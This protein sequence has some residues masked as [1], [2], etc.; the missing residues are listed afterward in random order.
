MDKL[1][2]TRVAFVMHSGWHF[3]FQ[4]AHHFAERF[5]RAGLEVSVF[6]VSGIRSLVENALTRGVSREQR[7][8]VDRLHTAC[9]PYRLA[10]RSALV[11]R[12]L[13]PV[14]ARSF[15]RFA[16]REIGPETLVWLHGVNYVLPPE[17]LL[18][19]EHGFSLVDIC[20][21]F[22]AFFPDDPRT[23]ARLLDRERRTAAGNDL[24]LASAGRL[25][26]RL[27]PMSRR[28]ALV[29]NGVSAAFLAAGALPPPPGRRK[30]VAAYQGAFASWF[31]WE[32]FEEVVDLLPDVEFRLIGRVYADVRDRMAR[33]EARP[34]VKAVGLLPHEKL[35]AALAE[36]D[37]GLIPFRVNDLTLATDPIKLYEYLGCGLPVVSTPLPEVALRHRSDSIRT[38]A[39]AA[40]FAQAIRDL[41]ALRRD[42]AGL[43]FRTGL[44]ADNTWDR[45][46]ETVVDA[47]RAGLERGR[48]AA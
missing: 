24:V 39:T 44:A 18:E 4:R 25:A 21:D 3:L 41:G 20:D 30:L 35:P 5:R 45:R 11:E 9:Y 46:F 27:R 6:E 37:V 28:L 43:A 23:R 19:R 10:R 33:L 14:I 1:P 2:F 12:L 36:V 32:L 42:P 40:E 31:D 17:V 34:N 38:A 8:T 47:I 29:R 26:D 15:R 13:E 7:D 16:R 48:R 22:A